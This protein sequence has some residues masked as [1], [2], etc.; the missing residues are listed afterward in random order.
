MAE[1]TEQEKI[2]K[3][4]KFYNEHPDIPR[5]DDLTITGLQEYF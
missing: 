4:E 2:E 3:R 1:L 5:P